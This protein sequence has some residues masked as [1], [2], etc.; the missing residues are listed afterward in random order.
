V[1]QRL[2]AGSDESFI[3][4]AAELTPGEFP[5]SSR[6]IQLAI[7]TYLPR[8]GQHRLPG[9]G[10]RSEI[11]FE[12]LI[13]LPATDSATLAATPEYQR[14][15][16]RID[17]SSRDD[18]GRFSHRPVITRDRNDGRF[19][20][21]LVITNRGRFGRD[22]TFYP[23]RGYNRGRLRHATEAASSIADWYLDE[24]AGLLQLRLPW[25]LL[26]VTDPSTRTL[27]YDRRTA[28]EFGTVTAGDFHFGIVIYRKG[29]RPEVV[30]ALP[31]LRDGTWQ[32]EDFTGWSWKGWAE[33]HSHS[34]LKPVYDSLKSLWLEAP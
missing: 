19:D 26:N 32:A 15:D 7:D 16:S 22:G 20:S 29:E 6:G 9:T 34:R 25:D 13:D 14:Y 33:P 21:L 11:G 17:P 24:Q 10:I 5:W 30:N 18:L 3:Y 27:L 28:G 1:L 2:R 23:A 4:M 31:E 8:I 12:F